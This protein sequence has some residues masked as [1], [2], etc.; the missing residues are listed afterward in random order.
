MHA[1]QK[2]GDLKEKKGYL[3]WGQQKT[4][5]NKIHAKLFLR[6][7]DV[8]SSCYQGCTKGGVA[9]RRI[10]VESQTC[11]LAVIQQELPS[12]SRYASNLMSYLNFT[13]PCSML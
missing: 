1:K 6:L 5:H 3:C 13:D 10:V 12:H 2:L 4:Q 8:S 11:T 9:K 7:Y